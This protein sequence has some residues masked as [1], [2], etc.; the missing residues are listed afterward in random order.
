MRVKTIFPARNDGHAQDKIKEFI[1]EAPADNDSAALELTFWEFNVVLGEDT[2]IER[3]CRSMSTGDIAICIDSLGER[4]YICEPVGWKLVTAEQAREWI[5]L[6]IRDRLFGTA[7]QLKKTV[8]I[9]PDALKTP[10]GIE[11]TNKAVSD[12]EAADALY[13]R[14]MEE[15][16][17]VCGGD[18][19]F[20]GFLQNAG[21]MNAVEAKEYLDSLNEI[22]ASRNAAC[23]ELVRALSGRPKA[24]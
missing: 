17:K 4:I 10:E 9:T 16:L 24:G 12:R 22:R 14:T 21:E 3:E 5:R 18:Y 8:D 19:A 7:G 20:V 2:H 1:W 15:I 11:R 23:E 13:F 6:P